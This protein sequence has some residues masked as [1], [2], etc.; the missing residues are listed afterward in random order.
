[1]SASVAPLPQHLLSI[2]REVVETSYVVM[3]YRPRRPPKPHEIRDLRE[4]DL[5]VNEVDSSHER[6]NHDSYNNG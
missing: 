2:D 1:M 6:Y 4:S 5:A 3:D